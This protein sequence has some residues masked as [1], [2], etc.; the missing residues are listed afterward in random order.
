[1]AFSRGEA[2]TSNR[3]FK[4]LQVPLKQPPFSKPRDRLGSCVTLKSATLKVAESTYYI[5]TTY[6][7]AETETAR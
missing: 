1:M 2:Q 4:F 5:V 6:H 7:G 3:S